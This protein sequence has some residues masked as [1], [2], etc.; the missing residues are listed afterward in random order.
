MVYSNH[1]TGCKIGQFSSVQ[2]GRSVRAFVPLTLVDDDF[3]PS[4]KISK[5][6]LKLVRIGLYCFRPLLHAVLF[7]NVKK[8]TA[9][10]QRQIT[11]VS[12]NCLIYYSLKCKQDYH[13]P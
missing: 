1:M 7:S 3:T 2:L 8:Y 9:F 5:Y 12:M 13:L 10:R 6:K 11:N 4:S